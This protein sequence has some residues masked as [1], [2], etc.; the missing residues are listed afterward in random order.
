MDSVLLLVS[1]SFVNNISVI[2]MSLTSVIAE[3][4]SCVTSLA[5]RAVAVA[6]ARLIYNAR[7]WVKQILCDIQLLFMCFDQ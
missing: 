1:I 3:S 4:G 2:M 6:A 7:Y 5:W